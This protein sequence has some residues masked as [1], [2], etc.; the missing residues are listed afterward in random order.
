MSE[1]VLSAV[2]EMKD[3]MSATI[4][5]AKKNVS[6]FKSALGQVS[7]AADQAANSL[8]KVGTAADQMSRKA[9][10]VKRPLSIFGRTYNTTLNVRDR[11]TPT[12]NRVKTQL[13]G[14]KGKAYTATI[15]V[16]QNLNAGGGIGGRLSRGVNS[17]AGGMLMNTSM[18]MLGGAGIGFGLYNVIKS[19]SD[20]EKEMSAVQAISGATGEDFQ[21]LT[22]KAIKMGE[23]TKF[24]ASESAKALGYMAMA[25]WNTK[26]MLGGLPGVM[27]LAAAS[28]ED[29]ASVSDIVT[30]AMTAFKLEASDAGHFA[31]VLAAASANANTNVGMMGYTFKYAASFAGALGYTV[32]DVALATGAMADAGVKADSAGTALRGIMER[33]AKPTKESQEAMEELGLEAFDAAGKAKPLRV[34]LEDIRKKMRGLSEQDQARL[35]SMLAGTYGSSGLLGLVNESEDKWNRIKTAIDNA[36]GSAEKMAKL[37]LDNLSGD[38][39][40]LGSAW[41]SFSIKLM[42]TS[43]AAGGLR[44]FFQEATNLVTHLS[45]RVS[46]EGLGP[47]A[48]IETIGEA[49]GDLTNKFLALD[50]VGSVLA[51]GLLIGS[52]YKIAKYTNRAI[53]SIKGMTSAPKGELPGAGGLPSAR[54]MVVNANTVVVNGTTTGSS[55]GP[56]TTGGGTPAGGKKGKAFAGTRRYGAMAV[57]AEAIYGAYQVY[58]A[59]EEDRGHAAATAGAGLVGGIAGEQLGAAI[60][61]AIGTAIAPGVGTAIGTTLGSIIGGVAGG[62]AGQKAVNADWGEVL[63]GVRKH[64]ENLG[65]TAVDEWNV[66]KEAGDDACSAMTNDSVDTGAAISDA[67]SSASNAVMSAWNGITEWFGGIMD[68]LAEMASSAGSRISSSFQSWV[69]GKA[70]ALVSDDGSQ[71]AVGDMNFAGGLTLMNEHGGELVDLPSGSRIYPAMETRQ[72]IDREVRNGTSAGPSVNVTGNTFMVREEADIDKIAYAIAKQVAMAEANYGGV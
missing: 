30:D 21:K 66:S 41:E 16:R 7:P 15:N 64:F 4:K 18:Q 49:V 14:L 62:A 37:R 3:K 38:I 45:D 23:T 19:Y 9:E 32:E 59:P 47:K 44:G 28:G 55:T 31:D 60:G 52:L 39:T 50:G 2:L 46:K 53:D 72:I 35:G 48:I 13:E 67:F 33:L 65:K 8:A 69:N 24:T 70:A 6:G 40:L 1:Y 10:R 11:V 27:N 17:V 34:V 61:G 42:K 68:S 43:D 71:A 25:G 36:N 51:G 56:V 5:T 54:N 58:T 29:L 20:F 57:A 22:D 26:E 63:A 12:L